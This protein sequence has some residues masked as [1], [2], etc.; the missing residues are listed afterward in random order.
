[1]NKKILLTLNEVRDKWKVIIIFSLIGVLVAAIFSFFIIDESYE[2]STKI[3]IGKEKFKNTSNKYTNEE[4]QMYQNLL[5][6]YCEVVKSND[7]IDRSINQSGINKSIKEV[8][9]KIDI[10]IIKDSQIMVIKYND[11]DPQVAYDM[12]YN[13]TNNFISN[14]KKLYKNSNVV[15]LQQ[16]KVNNKSISNY[17]L[18]IMIILGIAYMIIGLIYIYVREYFIS[19]FNTKEKIEYELEVNVLAVIP[20]EQN[21]SNYILNKY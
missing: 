5:K 7:L 9:K 17:A 20:N 13:I 18:L 1:M 3:F 15:V 2:A 4:V 14:S 10:D 16:I 21:V 19:T 6:T 8:Y 12:L 11:E